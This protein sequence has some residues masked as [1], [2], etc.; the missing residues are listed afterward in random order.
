VNLAE[1][2]P[3]ATTAGVSGI[4][5]GAAVVEILDQAGV[6]VSG[7]VGA[8]IAGSL[9]TVALFVGRN[10]LRGVWNAILNGTGRHS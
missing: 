7:P 4:G 5:G 1:K 6:H 3:N 8:L 10:G 2:H 9:A